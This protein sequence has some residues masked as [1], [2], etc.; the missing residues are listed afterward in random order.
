M[1]TITARLIQ[2]GSPFELQDA[3]IDGVPCKI[4]P[5][6]AQ[7][8]LQMYRKAAALGTREFIVDG[9][10]RLT[11]AAVFGGAAHVAAALAAGGC[12]PRTRVALWLPNGADWVTAFI[13]ITL[14]G[15]VPVLIHADAEPASARAAAEQAQAR[16]VMTTQPIA[17]NELTVE[18]LIARSAALAPGTALP[19][20]SSEDI[21]LIGFT[22][23]TTGVP[24]GIELSHR[25]V[26]TG[27]MNMMLGGAIAG[28]RAAVGNPST[29]PAAAVNYAPC[30]MLFAPLSHISGFAQI[31]LMA[32]AGGKVVL[33]GEWE[34]AEILTCVAQEKVRSFSGA[35]PTLLRKVLFALTPQHDVASLASLQLHGA[36]LRKEFID[37]VTRVLPHVMIGTGYGM[38]ETCGSVSVT[39]G[40]EFLADIAA[41]GRP[42][43]SVEVRI[44]GADG[45][46]AAEGIAG[47]LEVRG[48]MVMRGYCGRGDAPLDGG[49]LKTG[50][51]AR[52]EAGKLYVVD[53]LRDLFEI[54][55]VRHSANAI[56]GAAGNHPA[57][58]EAAIVTFDA[59]AKDDGIAIAIVLRESQPDAETRLRAEILGRLAPLNFT[60]T[61]AFVDAMPRT[62]SGKINRLALKDRVHAIARYSKEVP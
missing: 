22:S 29:R 54:R 20:P 41:S 9:T 8:L 60:P 4:F 2:R 24:K 34:T 30:S 42:L 26:V 15:C 39:T 28:A 10:R 18:D 21:A 38:T 23:G 35:T 1:D 49:W 40:A 43:P 57:V 55:G 48:A 36:A 37:E 16:L 32:H 44:M 17:P 33:A 5:R 46:P 12:A 56:E 25:N 47:E 11:F 6:G 62:A 3:V 27:L 50:D 51:F 13:G 31:L 61:L 45:I 14:A 52:L 53:R 7:N 58:D 19:E 59:A